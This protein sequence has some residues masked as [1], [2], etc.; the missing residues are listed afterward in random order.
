M[1]INL[2]STSISDVKLG[3]NQ[4]DKV[5]LGSDVVW[6][7]Q[8]PVQVKALRF[9]S[10]GAQTLGINQSTLG[11]VTP[12]FEYSTD[13]QT[14]TSWDITTTLSFG[15][16][17]D[18]YIRGS[19]IILAKSGTN[20]TNFV[21]STNSPVYCYGNVMH[22]IDYTQDLAKFPL[23]SAS[24]GLKYLFANCTA[25]VRPPSLPAT[26]LIGYAYY[27]MFTNCTS[28]EF[29][30]KLYNTDF[31]ASCM[32][33]MYDGCTLIKMSETQDSEYTNE[34]SVYTGGKTANGMFNNTGCTFATSVIG[35]LTKTL[36]TSN[37]VID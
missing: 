18:L 28:L 1:S 3:S 5:Y 33:H 15:S 8:A 11:T 2:G 14:W 7:K 30:P 36:Y 13:G 20:Y 17:T 26:V 29:I 10:A 32:E 31:P 22:L 23:N 37:S 4:V 6:Q 27:Y 19:N 21:F 35:N 24:R 16:G 12:N 9:T 25:L 34:Y